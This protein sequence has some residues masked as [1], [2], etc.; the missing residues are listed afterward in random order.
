MGIMQERATR[1]DIGR[2]SSQEKGNTQL[3]RGPEGVRAG[4]LLSAVFP[5]PEDLSMPPPPRP[6]S[7]RDATALCIKALK[8]ESE[9]REEEAAVKYEAALNALLTN[10][11]D[12]D[13][14]EIVLTVVSRGCGSRET[15]ER[16]REALVPVI[17][18]IKSLSAFGALELRRSL[19]A[20]LSAEH[21]GEDELLPGK[22]SAAVNFARGA[23]RTFN[24]RRNGG[25]SQSGVALVGGDKETADGDLFAA[26]TTLADIHQRQGEHDLAIQ[27]FKKALT[28]CAKPIDRARVLSSMA[29]AQA[30]QERNPAGHTAL[31]PKPIMAPRV[32]RSESVTSGGTS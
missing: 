6:L 23:C 28:L 15:V 16:A 7:G 8:Q 25:K 29:F 5:L 9:G 10:P 31:A 26:I 27:N 3:P 2:G 21:T 17:A 18:S 19:D 13:V 1:R 22:K 20:P 11:G 12:A 24:Q 30:R 4:S 14:P 32:D